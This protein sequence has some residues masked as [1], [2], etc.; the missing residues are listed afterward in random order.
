LG[1][2]ETGLIVWID[3]VWHDTGIGGEH[4]WTWQNVAFHKRRKISCLAERTTS[5]SATS[6]F[7]GNTYEFVWCLQLVGLWIC[8]AKNGGVDCTHVALLRTR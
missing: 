5:F 3:F 8:T 6:L 7:H 4:L 2:R 1:L